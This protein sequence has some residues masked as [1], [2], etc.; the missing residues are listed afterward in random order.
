[1]SAK[2]SEEFK[3]GNGERGIF[4]DSPL[5]YYKQVVKPGVTL[6]KPDD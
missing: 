2:I 4:G 1:M 5:K 3:R 6:I